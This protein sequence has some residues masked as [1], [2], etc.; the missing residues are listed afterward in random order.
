[1]VAHEVAERWEACLSSRHSVEALWV[2]SILSEARHEEAWLR[3]VELHEAL[4]RVVVD[5]EAAA[6]GAAPSK[7]AA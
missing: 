6:A 2:A 4:I 7:P 3:R 5:E 1:M